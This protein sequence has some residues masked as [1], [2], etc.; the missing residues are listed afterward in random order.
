ME[1]SFVKKGPHHEKLSLPGQSLTLF[2]GLSAGQAMIGEGN[3][4]EFLGN[5]RD[6]LR[7]D[8]GHWQYRQ[9]RHVKGSARVAS[10]LFGPRKDL[11]PFL[12]YP[13]E[14]RICVQNDGER[15]E[16]A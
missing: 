14:G 1:P 11:W 2:S 8:Q 13:A 3:P 9:G 7:Y 6:N 4:H 15:R 16:M 10:S 12:L 5:V